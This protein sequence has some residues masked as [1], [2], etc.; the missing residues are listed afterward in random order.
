MKERVLVV[1][2]HPDDEVLGC[3][4]TIARM[5]KDGCEVFV[6]ILG[7][8]ITSRYPN[9]EGAF[10][11]EL[12]LLREQSE[13]ANRLL[14]VKQLFHHDLP[15]NR[16]DTIPMLDIVKK[17]ETIIK[18]VKPEVIYTHHDGD[19][20]IDHSITNRAV[21]TATR[22]LPGSSVREVY[23]FETL[24]STEW[25][26]SKQGTQFAANAFCDISATLDEKIEAIKQ[27]KNELHDFPHPRSCEAIKAAAM[28]WGSLIGVPYA[29]AFGVVRTMIKA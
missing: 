19:L 6:L 29:E 26:F 16:F 22:P 25:A 1:T 23:T 24:S 17:I 21:L 14:G 11:D 3:G 8:G 4:G 10:D 12:K 15:D 9:R 7:E 18:Q 13:R 5:G 2:A 28:K 20:N 27:Y